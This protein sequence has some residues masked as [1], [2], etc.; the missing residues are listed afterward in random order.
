MSADSS[1]PWR[2]DGTRGQL[3]A[4][5]ISAAVDL[6]APWRGLSQLVIHGAPVDGWLLALGVDEAVTSQAIGGP[7]IDAALWQ[8]T[9]AFVRGRDLVVAYREPLGLPYSVQVYWRALALDGAE[10][11]IDAIVSV[12]TPEWETY[13]RVL[14]STSLGGEFVEARSHG[15]TGELAAAVWRLEAAAGGSPAQPQTWSYAELP[16]PGDFDF[17]PL[18]VG[19]GGRRGVEWRFDGQFMERGVIR[20]LRIRGALLPRRDDLATA[21]G[22]H[23]A[24]VAEQPPLT[25]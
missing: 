4:G 21:G 13:P 17:K 25:A 24:L 3:Q 10:A 16:R 2:L 1:D 8:P 7:P 6:A 20:R 9:D 19:E 15:E 5:A 23:A 18:P 14:L 22:L 12:Q 11:A